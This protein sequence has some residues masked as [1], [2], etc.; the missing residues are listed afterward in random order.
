MRTIGAVVASAL[1]ARH[2]VVRASRSG[3]VR[4]DLENPESI[5]ALFASE[6]GVDAVICCAASVK[7][8]PLAAL[9]MTASRSA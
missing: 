7:L 5:S 4:A 2:E 9:S 3:P 8:A 6:S 1:E